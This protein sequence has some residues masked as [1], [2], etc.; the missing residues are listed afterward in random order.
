M[1]YSKQEAIANAEKKKASRGEVSKS[2]AQ[3]GWESARAKEATD[4]TSVPQE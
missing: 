1:Y 2:A 3:R 4:S